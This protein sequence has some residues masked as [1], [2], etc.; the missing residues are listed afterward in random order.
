[1]V[2]YHAA[3]LDST[4]G[5]LSDATRR[6]IISRLARG[7]AS[8]GELAKPFNMSLPAVSKHIKILARAGLLTQEKQGRVK[9]CSLAARPLGAADEWIQYYQKFWEIQLSALDDY[10]SKEK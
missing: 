9:R 3:Q 6:A 8:V 10:L 2:N 1:M 7:S 4:F 5:A